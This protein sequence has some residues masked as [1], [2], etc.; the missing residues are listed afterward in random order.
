M[1]LL[2]DNHDS[3]TWNLAQY[4]MELG[5][6][7]RVELSDAVGVDEVLGSGCRGIVISPGPGRPERA[8]ITV[9]LIRRAAGRIPV[10]GVCLGHQAIAQA[11]G[12]RIIRAGR[13]MHGKTSPVRHDGRG[14]FAGMGNPFE[15]TRYH[16]LVVDPNSVPPE[17]EVTAVSDDD[18]EQ[19]IMGLRHR[20]HP[21]V[22]L[23]GVQFH[24]ESILTTEGKKLVANFIDAVSSPAGV[25]R[26]LSQRGVA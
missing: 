19:V 21:R 8:G 13:P 1:I 10:L 25:A 16:S 7:V 20:R 3:F 15:A 2:L 12:G 26:V 24:P 4:L 22:A 11:F 6:R 14:V 18:G 9:E 23:E 17:L 5:A